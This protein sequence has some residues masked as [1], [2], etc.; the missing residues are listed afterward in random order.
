MTDFETPSTCVLGREHPVARL[1]LPSCVYNILLCDLRNHTMI[2]TGLA[3]VHD[4]TLA[5]AKRG[6]RHDLSR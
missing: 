1:A 4:T 3:L 2:G 5:C 6:R